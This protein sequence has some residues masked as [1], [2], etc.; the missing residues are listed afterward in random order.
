MTPPCRSAHRVDQRPELRGLSRHACPW[1][2]ARGWM[3]V[4][5]ACARVLK[6]SRPRL[7]ALRYLGAER[8]ALSE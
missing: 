6:A 1:W 8:A 5:Y 3:F 2:S 7:A 4:R